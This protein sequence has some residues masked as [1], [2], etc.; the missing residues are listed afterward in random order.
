MHLCRE[1]GGVGIPI[2]QV[3]RKRIFPQQ[4][5]AYVERPDQVIGAQHVERSGHFLAVM[6]TFFIH[7][8]FKVVQLLFIDEYAQVP[9]D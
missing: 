2:K 5:V 6:V 4:V 9:G 7:G 3:K 1:S 8:I